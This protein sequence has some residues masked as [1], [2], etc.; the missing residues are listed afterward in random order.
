MKKLMGLLIVAVLSGGAPAQA[1]VVINEVFINPPGSYD[2]TREFIELMGTP[3]KKLDGYAIAL[4]NG[5]QWKYWTLGSPYPADQE[6]DE[7]FSLDGLELGANGL[8]VLAINIPFYYP[9]VLSDTNFQRWNT[10]WNGGLDSPGKLQNDGSNTILL[11]RNRPGKTQA[12]PTGT[13]C[14]G[15]DI[16]HDTEYYPGVVDPKDPNSPPNLYVQWGNGNLDKGSADEQPTALDLKGASTPEI[17]DDLEVVDEVSYEH[18]RGWEYDID[19]RHVDNGSTNPKFPRRHVHALDDP[20]GFSPDVL[21][22]VDY[23]T[24]GPGWAPTPGATGEM[25]NGNNWQDTATEQWIRGDSVACTSGCSGAGSVPQFY[26]D[27]GPNDNPDAI[28]PYR[29]HVPLWLDNGTAPDYTFTAL[30]TYQ[31]MA[32]RINPLAVPFIPGDCN[33]DGVCDAEDIAKISAVFG[34]ADW[35]FSNS[36]ADAPEGDD[37]DPAE[38]TRPWDVNATGENGVEASDLQWTLNFQGDTTGRIVGVRYDSTTPSSVGVYLNDNSTVSCTVTASFHVPSDR[39]LWGLT[40]GDLVEVTVM[41]QVTGGAILTTGQENGIMQYV[42]DLLLDAEGVLKVNSVM[43]QGL[44]ATTRSGLQEAIGNQGDLGMNTINGY[45]TSF[46]QGLTAPVALYVVT[47]EAIGQGAARVSVNPASAERFAAGTPSGLKVGRT[48]QHGNPNTADYPIAQM[49]RVDMP[50]IPADFDHDGDVD[51]DDFVIFQS[52]ATGPAIAHNGSET[53]QQADLD[54]DGDVDQDD[55]AIF[56]R[57][58]SGKD[59]PANPDCANQPAP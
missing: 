13:L 1:V 12:N 43:P 9:T 57:C 38:Q 20:Q 49:V 8:L 7:F 32:G 29:T 3:G 39:P 33:R 10:I 25:A 35:I 23:R 16:R 24:K 59:N 5:T 52:C 19:G 55:F 54:N 11:I 58:F 50:E 21:T 15:K 31:I 51:S 46:T 14:W 36:F 18:E 42:H 34:D 44:F 22:R 2:D 48:N 27:N 47:L 6:I 4:A 40:T 56:Q 53:C 45:T 41:A 17:D 37:G 28:Q 30:N 26:Y